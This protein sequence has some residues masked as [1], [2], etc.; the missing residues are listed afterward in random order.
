MEKMP[1]KQFSE[2]KI[3]VTLKRLRKKPQFK[4]VTNPSKWQHLYA[5]V[6]V[7]DL[8]WELLLARSQLP[9]WILQLTV[10]NCC[11]LCIFVCLR[12]CVCTCV[13]VC[14]PLAYRH[15]GTPGD[16]YT[17]PVGDASKRGIAVGSIAL[18]FMCPLF[19]QPPP[20]PPSPPFFING[21]DVAV[22]HGELI[23]PK[24]TQS[25]CFHIQTFW[26]EALS[27]NM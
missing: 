11:L 6:F 24:T 19:F 12:V 10:T 2:K 7:C 23:T 8:F 21:P 26:E 15:T 4:P 20:P 9:L 17:H 5:C 13:C 18:C 25:C 14:S 3:S 1:N 16:S 27:C 22:A